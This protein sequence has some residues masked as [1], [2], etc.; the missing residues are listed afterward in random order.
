METCKVPPTLFSIFFSLLL[1]FAFSQSEYS[2]YLHT[3][4]DR[5]LFNLAHLR[6]KTK[7]RKV[8]IREMR[9]VD[10]AA[11]IAQTEDALQ[12]LTNCFALACS[13]F[14]LTISAKKTKILGQD[15]SSIPSISNGVYTLGVVEDFTN[16]GSTIS[17]NLSLDTELNKRIGKAAATLAPLGRRVW[18]NTMLT[19]STK[20]MV[21]QACVLST[22]LYGS[23]TWILYSHQVRKLNTFHLR[24][25]WQ[26]RVP[27]KDVLDML[28][29]E[30][31]TGSRPAGRPT[32]RFKDVCKR[33]LNAGNT[34]PVGKLQL[35]TAVA[36]GLPL[37]QTFRRVRR[38]ERSNGMRGESADGREQHQHP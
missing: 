9:F 23:E 28:Y 12:Q 26:D 2:L 7:V 10:D 19:I 24:I 3:R 15:V 11:L 29:G 38:R 33:D 25:T 4:S 31:A 37:R 30:L 36:G 5:N 27:D 8:L 18:D 6:A 35:Q 17:S 14:G 32:L 1:S 34:N 20:I 21:Y 22:L 13:E 16:L